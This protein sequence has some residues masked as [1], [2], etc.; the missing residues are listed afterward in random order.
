MD[1]DGVT[2]PQQGSAAEG[3]PASDDDLVAKHIKKR[4]A[5][6]AAR[7]NPLRPTNP[8]PVR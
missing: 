2:Y 1:R 6:A 4:N 7:P 3:P 5:A 8:K